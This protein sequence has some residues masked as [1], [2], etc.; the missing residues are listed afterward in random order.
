MPLLRPLLA[1]LVLMCLAG[2]VHAQEVSATDRA[3]IQGI[4][5]QQLDAFRRDD[6]PAAFAFAAPSI[7]SQFGT[8]ERFLDMVR[9]AYPP[10][11]R[12]RA[13]EFSELLQRDGGI[14]QQ[15]ELVGPDGAAQL[16]LYTMERDGAGRWRIAGCSLV[17]SVRVGA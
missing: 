1:A 3:A 14:V 16:A 5:T 13:V 8:P 10:V 17:P 15:V 11:H 12:P 2:G 6:G 4:I 7:Q 9:R